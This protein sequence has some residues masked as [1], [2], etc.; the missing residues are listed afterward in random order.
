MSVLVVEALEMVDI[1]HHHRCAAFP[2]RER[3]ISCDINSQSDRPGFSA[4]ASLVCFRS[5][6]TVL[7]HLSLY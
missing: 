7:P 3:V 2:R 1:A 6:T 4:G 5:S